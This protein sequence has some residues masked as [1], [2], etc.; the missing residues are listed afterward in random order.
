MSG[1]LVRFLKG[2]ATK[3]EVVE[4]GGNPLDLKDRK[5]PA[6]FRQ[7]LTPDVSREE[8]YEAL[9]YA[10]ENEYYDI[11][12]DIQYAIEDSEKD[13]RA[14]GVV[15]SQMKMVPEGVAR[16]VGSYL[17]GKT[18]KRKTRKQKKTRKSLKVKS[19]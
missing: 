5:N 7:Y 6:I 8:L 13:K 18:K 1:F 9:K 2:K 19:K 4:R 16:K 11:E 12:Q 17:G 15:Q 10:Q 3:E 14:Y